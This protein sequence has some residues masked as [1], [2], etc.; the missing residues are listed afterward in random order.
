MQITFESTVFD[1]VGVVGLE[2]LP[3]SD[4]SASTRRVTRTATLDGQAVIIDNGYTAADS[5]LAVEAWLSEADLQRLN[6]LIRVY[7]EI[8]ATTPSG[9]YLGVIDSVRQGGEG[10]TQISYLIQRTLALSS[11]IEPLPVGLKPIEPPPSPV[12][13]GGWFLYDKARNTLFK[14]VGNLLTPV[15][16]PDQVTPSAAYSSLPLPIAL[17]AYGNVVIGAWGSGVSALLSVDKGDTWT[18]LTW[19]DG[20]ELETPSCLLATANGFL[21]NNAYRRDYSWSTTGQIP[22]TYFSMP[23][24]SDWGN[25][26]RFAEFNGEVYASFNYGPE[27]SL[28][29][30]RSTDPGNN[31]WEVA[32]PGTLGI[33]WSDNYEP[34]L[35]NLGDRLL[36]LSCQGLYR[37]SFDGVTWSDGVST[38]IKTEGAYLRDAVAGS[39][40]VIAID[41]SGQPRVY[42][43]RT[44]D[45]NFSVFSLPVDTQPRALAFGGGRFCLI[46]TGG[47]IISF[48]T[49]GEWTVETWGVSTT[50]ELTGVAYFDFNT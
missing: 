10:R 41:T 28:G 20:A 5:T 45:L 31:Q 33:G 40:W 48:A 47:S 30:V 29:I 9:C 24:G 2:A 22:W 49:P 1:P 44:T 4:L 42:A 12:A 8:I 21:A 46:G 19:S 43:A 34:F 25:I 39:G 50:A 14:Y 18:G 15:A 7:P 6:H 16:L 38:L 13:A 36:C 27:G 3:G 23:F 11:E 32:D 37:T 26:S 17:D 35:L